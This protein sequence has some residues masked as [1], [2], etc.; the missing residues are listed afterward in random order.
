MRH[1]GPGEARR[2]LRTR[3]DLFLE[4]A[5]RRSIEAELQRGEL[6]RVRRGW[7]VR[8]E[9]WRGLWSESRHLLH[10]WAVMEGAR[11]AAVVASHTA[12]AVMWGLP[13]WRTATPRVH[14]TSRTDAAISSGSD[15]MRH[16]LEL[17]ESD[18]T[19]IE[20]VPCTT[21]ERTVFDLSRTLS[22][23]AALAAADAGMRLVSVDGFTVDEAA[24][25]QWREGMRRRL[26]DATGVR[27]V[28]RARWTAETADGLAQLPGESVSRLQLLRL[29]FRRLRLQVPVPSPG[30]SFYWVDIGIEDAATWGE[31][32][33]ATKY[34][35]RVMR[36]G[37]SI[38]QVMLDEKQREDWIRG[39]TR[40]PL[41][42][43]GDRHIG[44]P[45]ALG[46]RLAAFGVRPPR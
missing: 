38:E 32:D 12:A 3:E 44:S 4:G 41:V 43:W 9:E 10:V 29:G 25:G 45:R 6:R 28:R 1:L 19:I 5:T 46:E 11:S 20:G 36:S 2:L 31:F 14:L 30:G 18:V 15:V 16:R 27:G 26:H 21:L 39:T 13:L 40:R 7:F 8:E 33:G 23:E 35:D 17:P 24:A 34:T 37:R 42:R 22:M